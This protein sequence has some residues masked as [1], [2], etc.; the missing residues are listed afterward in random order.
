M[1]S[2]ELIRSALQLTDEGLTRLVSDMRD[3]AMVRGTP[4]GNHTLWSLGHLTVIEAGVPHIL[5]G[6]PNPVERWWPLFGMGSKPGDDASVYPSFDEVLAMF[7]QCRRKNL[8]LLDRLGESGL[9]RPPKNVPPGFEEVMQTC[10]GTLML[11]ALHQ[12]Q[13]HGQIADARRVAGRK[14]LV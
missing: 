3:A 13:H 7:R 4:G 12:M 11:I 9:D 10:G 14:P 5:V 6:E 8:E 1:K 2:T